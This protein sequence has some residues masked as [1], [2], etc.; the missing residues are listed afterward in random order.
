MRIA[1]LKIAY[2][3]PGLQIRNSQFA[4]RNFFRPDLGF[5]RAIIAGGGTGGHLNPGIAVA[6]EI[7]RRHP[8]SRILFVGADRGIETR[9]VPQEGFE[10]RTLPVGGIQREALTTKLRNLAATVSGI[11]KAKHILSDFKPDVVI[12]VGGYASFPTMAAA[13]LKRYPCLVMEQNA[14]PGLANRVVGRWVDFAAVPDPRTQPFFRGRAVV[15]GNPIRPQF[16]SVPAKTHQPP[17]TLLIFGGSQG[18]RAINNAV[19]DSLPLLKKWNVPL[20]FVHQTGE[21]QLDELK[22]AYAAAGFEA[23]VRAYFNDFHQQFAAA[24]LILS[25][26]G[27][28]TIDELKASGR[29]AILVPLPTAADDH[30][31]KN[32]QSMVEENAAMLIRNSELTGE[33]LAEA[34]RSL[35]SDAGH[36]AEMERNARRIAILDSERRIVDL[37]E[38]AIQ[39]RGDRV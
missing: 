36:I 14:I 11:F 15:T 2:L 31:T 30:Q 25:R 10:L 5:M 1:N 13:I 9:L 22:L 18:A 23:D 19:R 16:K 6:R 27:A 32:A 24:D 35:L 8:G 3:R 39:K 4:I 37:V 29:A 38:R 33:K 7:Q 17:Y 26:S 20:R 21:K 34:L 12:G 28:S